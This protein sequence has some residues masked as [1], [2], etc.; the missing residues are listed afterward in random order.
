MTA[1]E[2]P[3]TETAA[4]TLWDASRDPRRSMADRH[5]EM[6]QDDRA[7]AVTALRAA[8]DAGRDYERTTPAEVTEE[9]VEA[10]S[11]VLCRSVEREVVRAALEAALAAPTPPAEEVEL[12]TKH[13]AHL[14]DVQNDDGDTCAHM[15]LC[16]AGY[17][18]GVDQD[19]DIRAWGP[20][21]LT[22][23]TLPDGTRA[24]RDGERE[25]GK[26]RFVKEDGK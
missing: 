26:P 21:R 24:H 17:W 14:L 15:A 8:F 23:F 18:H 1:T 7:T 3:M 9:M 6:H 16:G 5:E 25:D 12:A 11:D 4:A 19:G 22:A 2:H 10:A 13:P 20:W